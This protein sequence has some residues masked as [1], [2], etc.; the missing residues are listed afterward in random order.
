[1]LRESLKGKIPEDIRM[2]KGKLA[3]SVPQKKWM[4]EISDYLIET[5]SNDFRAGKYIDK[6]R[7]IKIIKSRN[8]NDKFIYRAFALEKWMKV[9][10][11]NP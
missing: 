7:I 3:F 9:F 10:D 4:S 8:Y 11:L 2:R 6:N 1:M 5:F